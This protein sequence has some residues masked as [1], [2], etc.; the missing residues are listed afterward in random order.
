MLTIGC[1]GGEILHYD[2]RKGGK[3]LARAREAHQGQVCGVKWSHEGDYLIS[4]GNDN[5]VDVFDK[6]ELSKPMSRYS[7]HKAAVKTIEWWESRRGMVMTAS[8]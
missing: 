3:P 2:V 6:R 1:E 4:G 5:I 8:G 7:S